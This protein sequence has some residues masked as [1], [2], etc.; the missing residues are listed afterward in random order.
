[1]FVPRKAHNEAQ[2]QNQF[3]GI[4]AM[5]N[6]KTITVVLSY[7]SKFDDE[8]Q[9]ETGLTQEELETVEEA[10]I[11]GA[12]ESFFPDFE[13]EVIRGGVMTYAVEVEGVSNP[14]MAQ[15]IVVGVQDIIE[16][17]PPLGEV[18][19]PELRR[20]AGK[21]S[22]FEAEV[23]ELSQNAKWEAIANEGIAPTDAYT[24]AIIWQGEATEADGIDAAN[25]ILS[26]KRKRGIRSS[27][28][29]V[30]YVPEMGAWAMLDG[31]RDSD[32]N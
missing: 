29:S 32:T 31:W 27:S 30:T 21:G 13:V 12:V 25:A 26:T 5:S 20:L 8:W 22:G 16:S 23:I 24:V 14:D 11:Q 7:A 17:L 19:T 2:N 3:T 6:A 1:M 4:T 9:T 15:G 18:P 10:Q 28:D